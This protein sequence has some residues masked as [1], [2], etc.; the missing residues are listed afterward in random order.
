MPGQK[1]AIIA[2]AVLLRKGLRS[3]LSSYLD[4]LL[5]EEFRSVTD[6]L[7][8]YTS[9]QFAVIFLENKLFKE[10]SSDEE[11][12]KRLS[13]LILIG[14]IPQ[15]EKD[16]EPAYYQ[17]SISCSISDEEMILKLDYWKNDWLDERLVENN[18]REL[19]R[20][21]INVLKQV[22]LGKTNKEI[23]DALFLSP[24]TVIT[25]R[26]NITRKLGIYTVS[27]LTV[28]ALINNLIEPSDVSK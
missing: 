13:D 19:S 24:H 8:N 27:G 5:L 6:F 21:E 10:I 1:I 12:L 18:D 16:P 4:R 28:Y 14:I 23:A 26:K 17:D 11:I 9:N 22:A 7:S 20:R 15:G 2:D 25:H 3:L